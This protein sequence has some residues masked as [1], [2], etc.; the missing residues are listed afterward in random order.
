M[1]SAAESSLGGGGLMALVQHSVKSKTFA[2]YTKAVHTFI[3]FALG[4]RLDLSTDAQIDQA[5]TAY[6]TNRHDA[7]Q[8][9]LD[10]DGESDPSRRP[11]HASLGEMEHLLAGCEFFTPSLKS[12]LG[13]SHRA[14][15]A[16]R[17]LHPV[18]HHPPLN[19]P[20][21]LVIAVCLAK[22][23]RRDMSIAVIL[24]F[25]CYFRISE[26]TEMLVAHVVP[27]SHTDRVAIRLPTTKSRDNDSVVV[28]RPDV[29]RLLV[30]HIAGRSALDRVFNFSQAEFR[31]AFHSACATLGLH[32]SY[33]P[34]SL[35]GGGATHDFAVMDASSV[36]INHIMIR[37]RWSSAKSLFTYC[38]AGQSLLLK[39]RESPALMA[40]GQAIAS[41]LYDTMSKLCLE[42]A[43]C[44]A[45]HSS[46]TSVPQVG[47]GRRP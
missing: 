5:I 1:A 3:S 22:G 27:D 47:V 12:R 11:P 30:R 44:A 26:F 38:R 34:H 16:W 7:Y 10:D 28:A 20:L 17:K 41:T 24:A 33:V 37:G 18:E 32:G 35:R 13:L 14:T 36:D 29:A 23:G 8:L 9:W 43:E 42:P 4:R 15:K 45:P 19:W 31:I 40:T 25:D 39:V 6:I 46:S 21:T 2:L